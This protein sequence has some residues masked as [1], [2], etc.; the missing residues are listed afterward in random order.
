MV[1]KNQKQ[2]VVNELKDKF[3]RAKSVFTTKQL[4]LSVEQITNLRDQIREIGGEFKIA[5]N[6]LFRVAAQGTDFE[7]LCED[8]KG[9]TAF[10]FCYD[11]I[12]AP[13]GKVKKYSKD[14]LDEKVTLETAFIDGQFLDNEKAAKV[15]NLPP[16][17]VLLSQIAGLIVQPQSQ[18]A[19]MLTQSASEVASLL[20]QLGEKD[21]SDKPLKDFIVASS[22]SVESASE[23]GDNAEGSTEPEAKADEGNNKEEEN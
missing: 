14:E 7:P 5:K 12:V 11:D 2:E 3:S 8:L 9:P 4:G 10:L 20:Q 15:I 13:A 22:T 6:T 1:T 21:G 16:K 18:V 17:E 23:P 19:G